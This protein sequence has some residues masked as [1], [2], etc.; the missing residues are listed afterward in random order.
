MP[1]ISRFF[2][3]IKRQI[4]AWKLLSKGALRLDILIPGSSGHNLINGERAWSLG[5]DLKGKKARAK[6]VPGAL[7][8]EMELFQSSTFVKLLENEYEF[9][10][11][12]RLIIFFCAKSDVSVTKYWGG[13]SSDAV[14]LA[15]VLI[16]TPLVTGYFIKSSA[17]KKIWSI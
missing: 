2:G 1:E 16:F 4:L 8:L 10:A 15:E 9:F 17:A 3:I 12:N 5:I 7:P 11:L 6:S 14:L 13:G